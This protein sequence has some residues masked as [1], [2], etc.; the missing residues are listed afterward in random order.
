VELSQK[1]GVSQS[2][3][4]KVEAGK[5]EPGLPEILRLFYVF[6]TNERKKK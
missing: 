4:S 3:I 2:Y 5:L 1:S 6:E